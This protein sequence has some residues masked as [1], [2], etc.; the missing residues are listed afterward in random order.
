MWEMV[1]EGLRNSVR[2]HP[3][4]AMTLDSIE[5][6]VLEGLTTPTDA[7]ETILRDFGLTEPT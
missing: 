1:D 3:R 5:A 2:E 7:A 4:V 6:D